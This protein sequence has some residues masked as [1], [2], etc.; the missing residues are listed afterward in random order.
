MTKM[1][2]IAVSEKCVANGPCQSLLCFSLSV[3]VSVVFHN[4]WA[5]EPRSLRQMRA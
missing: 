5:D 1:M 3:G 2:M 4:S